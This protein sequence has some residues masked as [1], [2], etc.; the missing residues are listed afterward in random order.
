MGLLLVVLGV[1]GFLGVLDAVQESDDLAV[2]D[3]PVLALAV[4]LRS[5]VATVV[6][7]AV[8]AVSGP[9]VLPVVVLAACV[10]WG[11]AAR[12]WWGPV[13]LAVSMAASGLVV[14]SLK[15]V[16]ARP[17]PPA[18]AMTVPGVEES[19]SFPSG[20]TVGTATLLLVGG[21]LLWVR[22][23]SVRGLLGWIATVVVGVG[24]VALSRLYLGYHFV[25]DVVAS[26]AL[27]LAVLGAVVVLDR[28]R[29]VRGAQLAAR[30][31]LH[32]T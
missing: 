8:S 6:F 25:T 31:T 13:L 17:R 19:F 4:A 32:D 26:M 3:L 27:A 20:H 7:T 2:L 11:L 9:N 18:D 24:M 14:M 10:A 21:Y 22:R 1:A 23:P 30:A 16:V 15:A 5:D 12:A 29:A 28:R